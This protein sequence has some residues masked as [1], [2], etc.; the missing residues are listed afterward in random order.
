MNISKS[1]PPHTMKNNLTEHVQSIGKEFDEWEYMGQNHVH[2]IRP[3][4]IIP[5]I[6]SHL[7]L[8]QLKTV[9]LLKENLVERMSELEKYPLSQNCP[10]MKKQGW[11]E[12]CAEITGRISELKRLITLLDTIIQDTKNQI[13]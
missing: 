11:C 7:L 8:S 3:L 13:K 1:I 10:R 12:S 4:T 9:E 6:K 2:Q 5:E